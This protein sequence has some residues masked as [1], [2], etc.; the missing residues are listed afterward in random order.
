MQLKNVPYTENT[1]CPTGA[2][3]GL[4]GRDSTGIVLSCQ[5]GVWK[6][7]GGSSSSSATA[8]TSYNMLPSGAHAGQ[9]IPKNTSMI[10]QLPIPATEPAYHP[11]TTATRSAVPCS[12]RAG[13]NVVSIT[14][15]GA[16]DTDYGLNSN[17]IVGVNFVL[18]A[19]N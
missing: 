15:G 4:M 18:C 5:N 9:C 12:C 13:F 8:L 1:V 16:P 7:A 17:A 2:E 3:N 14:G 11:V 19:K 6:K 10:A